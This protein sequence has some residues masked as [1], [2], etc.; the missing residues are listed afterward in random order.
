MSL[1]E[2]GELEPSLREFQRSFD[3]CRLP[4]L[5]LN[6]TKLNLKL[7]QLQEARETYAQYRRLDPDPPE[8]LRPELKA[9][10]EQLAGAA[11]PT[12]ESSAPSSP[13]SPPSPPSPAPSP[14]P[15][16]APPVV[17]APMVKNTPAPR[18]LPLVLASGPT[19][20]AARPLH[21]RW[22]LWTTV[23]LVAAGAAVGLGV[24]LSQ[25][26]RPPEAALGLLIVIR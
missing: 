6:I 19:A 10:E 15:R 22:W 1:Y 17:T 14:V 16:T 23:G 26:Q 21:Q 12:G 4:P 18:K 25:A 8:R 11:A 7:G 20:P 5:L 9:L 3:V 2:R 13:P 24:G